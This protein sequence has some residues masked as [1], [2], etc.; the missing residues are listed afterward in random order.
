MYEEAG[1]KVDNQYQAAAVP[2]LYIAGDASCDVLQ[3][4]VA[5]S[6]GAQAAIAINTALLKEDLP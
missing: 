4:V 1:C 3:A 2:G 5:A 6:E